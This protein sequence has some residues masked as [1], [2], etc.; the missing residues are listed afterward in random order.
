V[1][2]D[3]EVSPRQGVLSPHFVLDFSVALRGALFTFTLSRFGRIIFT[4]ARPAFNSRSLKLIEFSLVGAKNTFL[5]RKRLA[6]VTIRVNFLPILLTQ[7][8]FLTSAIFN[9]IDLGHQAHKDVSR[10]IPDRPLMV[11]DDR[12][13]IELSVSEHLT[14]SFDTDTL[15]KPLNVGRH[16]ILSL[17]VGVVLGNCLYQERNVF[18][19]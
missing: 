3:S 11:T 16:D 2:V 1:H 19:S 8:Y 7:K 10:N 6:I 5:L 9:T 17:Q 12:E 14:Y 18:E 15:G 13:A 4:E